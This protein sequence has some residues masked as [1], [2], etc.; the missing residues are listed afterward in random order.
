MYIN[1]VPVAITFFPKY[2]HQKIRKAL[3]NSTYN[4]DY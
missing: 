3:A 2:N 4:K 1:Q